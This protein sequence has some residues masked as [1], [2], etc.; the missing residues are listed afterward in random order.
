[1]DATSPVY[2]VKHEARSRVALDLRSVLSVSDAIE[3][4]APHFGNRNDESSTGLRVPHERTRPCEADLILSRLIV[5]PPGCC[6]MSRKY[7]AR[8]AVSPWA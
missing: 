5:T 4:A 3:K 7:L 2:M 8:Q 6:S 1:M